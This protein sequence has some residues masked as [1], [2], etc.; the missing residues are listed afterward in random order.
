MVIYEV[1]LNIQAT[2]MD[3]FITWLKHHMS[4]VLQL[5]GFIQATTFKEQNDDE[6]LQLCIHYQTKDMQSLQNYFD[7]HATAMRQEGIDLFGNQF[8]ATRRVLTP[9]TL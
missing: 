7:H 3:K 1:N 5:D 6:S 9:R 2:I 4:D 8:S